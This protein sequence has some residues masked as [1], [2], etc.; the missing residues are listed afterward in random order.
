MYHTLKTS[1]FYIVGSHSNTCKN[2]QS[3]NFDLG[4]MFFILNEW[5]TKVLQN[6]CQTP[7]YKVFVNRYGS[8][9]KFVLV[10]YFLKCT[11]KHGCT[12]QVKI[13]G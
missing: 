7:I 13:G 11:Y 6:S 8:W 4:W 12:L 5:S 2:P 1:T 10:N 3:L 9:I